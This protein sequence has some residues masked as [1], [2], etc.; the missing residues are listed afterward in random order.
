MDNGSRYRE[1][2]NYSERE[3]KNRTYV[4]KEDRGALARVGLRQYNYADEY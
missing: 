4:P 3:H 2:N 1:L